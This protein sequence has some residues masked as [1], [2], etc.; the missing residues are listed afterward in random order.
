[1]K[2]IVDKDIPYIKDRI[3]RGEVTYLPAAEITPESVRDADALIVRTRTHCD[4]NLLGNSDVKFVA[5]AT[6]G[7][8]HIDLPWCESKGIKVT[9]APGCNAP[10]VAQYVL[11]SLFQLGFDPEKDSLGIVGY[12]NV[13]QIVA[14]WAKQ[15]GIKTLISDLPRR[16]AGRKDVEYLNLEEVLEKSDAVTLHVPLT[17]SGDYPTIGLIGEKE[18]KLMKPGGVIVNSSRGGVVNEEALKKFLKSGVLK[19]VTDVWI[20]EPNIDK[21]L[22]Q[23]SEVA[24]PHIAGYASEGKMRATS[25]SLKNLN[26]AFGIPVDLSG[27]ECKEP[28]EMSVSLRSLQESYNPLIDTENLKNNP[29]SFEKLRNNYHYRHEPS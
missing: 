20:N 28:K 16:E 8:D 9:N 21:E 26:E 7:T 22:L 1:M 2:I 10:G 12:G 24:T 25:M 4:E 27:L 6:I 23:F 3:L 13:G 18:L 15:I 17:D 14:K 5:T 19:G 29:D 11:T